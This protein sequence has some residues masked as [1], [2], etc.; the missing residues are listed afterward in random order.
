M[1]LFSVDLS[2]PLEAKLDKL[3]GVLTS[4][5][6]ARFSES[7]LKALN[8]IADSLE[9]S[10][11][12]L[13]KIE[14]AI[15]DSKPINQKSTVEVKFAM[16]IIA[17][18][19]KPFKKVVTVIPKDSE[20]NVITQGLPPYTFAAESDNTNAVAVTFEQSAPNQFTIHYIIGSPG[21]D[22]TDAIANVQATVVRNSDG[23]LLGS[24]VDSYTVTT[25]DVAVTELTFGEA[26][27]E[28]APAPTSARRR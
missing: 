5:N 17:D 10:Q 23:V 16:T 1:A 15:R 22:G 21:A 19:A 11:I 26:Q 28:D 12:I 14:A 24:G 7:Q 8:R 20:G 13:E 4:L 3:I 9:N 25:G 2:K 18:D 27:P 6:D